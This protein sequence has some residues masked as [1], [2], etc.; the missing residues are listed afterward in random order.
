MLALITGGRGQDG[1]I[2]IDF[3][4]KKKYITI[5]IVRRRQTTFTTNDI[6]TSSRSNYEVFVDLYDMESVLLLLKSVAEK[7]KKKKQISGSFHIEIYH[8]MCEKQGLESYDHPLLAIES[9]VKTTLNLLESI[10][11]LKKEECDCNFSLFF[12]GSSEMYGDLPKSPQSE[13]T[14]FSPKSPYAVGK[15]IAH[16][17]CLLYRE[18]YNLRVCTGILFNH[19]SILRPIQ[20][21]SRKVIRAAAEYKLCRGFNTLKLGN[22]SSERDW[23]HAYDTINGIHLAL[24]QNIMQD[25]VFAMGESHTVR[26][27]VSLAFKSIEVVL[28]WQGEGIHEEG[29]NQRT[30]ELIVK[31]DPSLFRE[32]AEMPCLIGDCRKAKEVLGWKKKFSFETM[33]NNLVHDE[34]RFLSPK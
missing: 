8:F 23:S 27:F 6:L 12:A 24:N 18:I 10:R 22:I 28:I 32:C 20:Y 34:I 7:A 25:F 26:E 17:T 30:G 2:M 1:R 13:T 16:Q 11:L 21:V 14:K 9:S 31:V 5:S 4:Q 33:I 19:E 29:I 15:V 3:L